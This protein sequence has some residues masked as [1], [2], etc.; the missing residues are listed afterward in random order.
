MADESAVAIPP[1]ADAVTPPATVEK[2]VQDGDATGKQAETTGKTFTQAELDAIV[3]DRLDRAAAKSKADT[4][5]A[6]ADEQRKAAEQQGEYQKLY[7]AA[8]AEL[9]A[10]EQKAQALELAT[11]RRDVA[12]K[13]GVPAALAGRLQGTTMEELEADA[14]ALVAALPKPTAPNLNAHG[15]GLPPSSGMSEQERIATAARLGVSPK[16]FG[17]TGE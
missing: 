4:D 7:E 1:A 3:K 8:K 2:P 10:A 6:R 13:L 15:G 14:K 11:M 9:T 16:Y 5:K 12:E 17:K